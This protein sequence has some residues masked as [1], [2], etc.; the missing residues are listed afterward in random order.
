MGTAEST[1]PAAEG[2]AVE[3]ATLEASDDWLADRAVELVCL[4]AVVAETVALEEAAA[5]EE[6]LTVAM[7][8]PLD[9][10]EGVASIFYFF[11]N[12]SHEKA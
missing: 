5:M 10:I 1:E 4:E 12:P 6:L 3:S 2:S 7:V 8:V 9:D 11:G